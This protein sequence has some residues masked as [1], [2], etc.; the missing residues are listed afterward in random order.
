[1]ITRRAFAPIAVA[2]GLCSCP[3][4][5]E[6]I[7]PVLPEIVLTHSD[8]SLMIEGVVSGTGPAQV[9]A[10]LSIEHEGSGGR[11]KTS[12]SR[13]LDLTT[14]ASRLPV[15]S[16]GL[17]FGEG[18]LLSVDLVVTIGDTIIAESRVT[19]GERD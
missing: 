1:M 13:E 6:T 17:N 5:S 7:S 4:M 12:Q 18:S 11:M 9:T 10:T 2:M 8:D 15:A 14:G 3:A 19:I 16:T